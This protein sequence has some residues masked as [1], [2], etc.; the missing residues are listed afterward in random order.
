MRVTD[1]QTFESAQRNI[2][3]AREADAIATDRAST[4]IRVT[5]PGDDPSGAGRM[6]THISQESRLDSIATTIERASDELDAADNALG[7]LGEIV[8]RA[9]ELAVQLANGTYGPNERANSANEVDSLLRNA[10]TQ[11]NV[12]FGD[13]YLFGGFSDGAPPFD[14]AGN[15]VGDTGV[16]QIEV[17]PGI[18]QDVSIRADV[19]LKG[20]GGGTD[21][22]ATLSG[23]ATAMRANNVA[24]IQAALGSLDTSTQQLSAARATGGG[25]QSL[26]DASLTAAKIG[27][28]AE[29]K[30]VAGIEEVNIFEAA[31]Q[32]AHAE[33]ALEASMA[34][35]AKS[36]ELTL[37]KR[38]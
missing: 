36:F 37:L 24:G 38:L 27:K 2:A 13:R 5:H 32:L 21:L 30:A 18:R 31:T 12:R 7:A 34:A 6:A 3:R 22:F 26:L 33:R 23:L 10:V 15:Y 17:A 9:R 20:A 25:A 8:T 14:A 1:R 19:A 35:S 4:G 16:R 28:D 29:T 11:A